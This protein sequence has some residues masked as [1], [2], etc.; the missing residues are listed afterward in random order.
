M[1]PTTFKSV[2]SLILFAGIFGFFIPSIYENL[3]GT[4]IPVS[5]NTI[6]AIMVLN[7]ALIYWIIMFKNR[8]RDARDKSRDI[9]H[10][11]TPP[12]PLVAARTVALAF[13]GS[14]AAS[15]IIGFYL[16]AIFNFLPNLELSPIQTRF[17][18][19]IAIIVA[20][21]ILLTLSLWLE[22]ICKITD[23]D[24]KPGGNTSFA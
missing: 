17:F 5:S 4:F 19:S 24:D 12:H 2:F 6:I 21:S 11:K 7:L 13:A 20:S 1:K 23:S 14:R 15:L 16:G 10:R 3:T 8:L 9:L 22:K 18:I